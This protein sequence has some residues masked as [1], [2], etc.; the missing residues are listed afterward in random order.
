MKHKIQIVH[1][2]GGMTFKNRA[3]YLSFLK[4]RPISLIK[5]KKWSTDYLDEKLGRAYEIIHIRMPLPENAKYEDWKIYFERHFE[6]LRPGVILLGNSLG[7]IFLAQYLAEEKFPKK[8]GATYLVAAPYDNTTIGED[9]V[10][11]FGFNRSSDLSL[12]QKNSPKLTLFF[13]Q[14]DDCVPIDH[15][16]KFRAK[17]PQANIVIY[18]SKNGHFDVPT[19]PELVKMIQEDIK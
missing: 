6:F 17:L 1:I 5:R 4:N 12:I 11:G 10:G 2:H 3:D 8:I 18:K 7:A 9:L 19:F 16:E 14:D 13:S 15:A